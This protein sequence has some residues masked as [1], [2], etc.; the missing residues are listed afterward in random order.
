MT[1][2]GMMKVLHVKLFCAVFIAHPSIV[3]TILKTCV[4]WKK[5]SYSN[6]TLRELLCDMKRHTQDAP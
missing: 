3:T 1:I 4:N 6:P 5:E 2:L